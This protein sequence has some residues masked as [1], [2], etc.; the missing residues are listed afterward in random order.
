MKSTKDTLIQAKDKL[1]EKTPDKNA[2][3][4][5]M[6]DNAKAYGIFIPGASGYIDS[7]FDSLDEVAS[8]HSEEVDKILKG[9]YDELRPIIQDGTMNQENAAKIFDILRRRVTELQKVASQATSDILAPFLEKHPELKDSLGS[10]YEEFQ[11]LT[12]DAAPEAKRIVTDTTK[13]IKSALENGVDAKSIAKVKEI[14]QDATKKIQESSSGAGK[15]AW[16]KATETA[17]PY[18]DKIPEIRDLLQSKASILIGAGGTADIW[19]RVKEIGEQK[20]KASKEKVE[21]VKSFIEQKVEEAQSGSGTGDLWDKLEDF[22]STIP[23]ADKVRVLN[24]FDLL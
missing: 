20:G 13:Q 10:G 4:K 16:D 11:R 7:T 2:I 9:A 24:M 21:E 5:F 8:T 17:K 23:G 14:I 18:L 6:R 19:S 12:K 22:A 3:L 15:E 1:V